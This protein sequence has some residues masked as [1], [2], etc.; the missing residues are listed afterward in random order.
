MQWRAKLGTFFKKTQAQQGAKNRV[1]RARSTLVK[2]RGLA[3]IDPELATLRKSL[4]AALG[5]LS[6]AFKAEGGPQKISRLQRLGNESKIIVRK[7][8][9]RRKELAEELNPSKEEDWGDEE[10]DDELKPMRM[11]VVAPVETPL[12]H[13]HGQLATRCNSGGRDLKPNF[14]VGQPFFIRSHRAGESNSGHV[15]IEIHPTFLDSGREQTCVFTLGLTG[16]A[17]PQSQSVMAALQTP[18][19]DD[20]IFSKNC[21]RHP[22]AEC[23]SRLTRFQDGRTTPF[24]LPPPHLP[25]WYSLFRGSSYE[26]RLNLMQVALLKCIYSNIV[27]EQNWLPKIEAWVTTLP[28]IYTHYDMLCSGSNCHSF[29]SSFTYQP[30]LL[31]EELCG[32]GRHNGVP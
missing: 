5:Q 15:F 23:L 22:V 7:I 27:K 9:L 25:T 1:R 32:K 2:T 30:E 13:G 10:S 8:M 28:Q 31:F 11:E 4:F 21:D 6:E 20:L 18:D 19:Q 17:N 12:A 24:L 14:G 26:G 3:L 16:H 29:A